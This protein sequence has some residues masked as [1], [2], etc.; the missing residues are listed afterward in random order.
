MSPNNPYL[1]GDE[2]EHNEENHQPAQEPR[3]QGQAA[4]GGG[5]PYTNQYQ[6]AAAPDL[7][8]NAPQLRSSDIKRMN[9]R[10]LAFLGG[11]VALLLVVA[12]WVLGSATSKKTEAPKQQETVTVPEAPKAF[13]Q[14]APLPKLPAPIPLANNVPPL[15]NPPMPAQFPPPQQGPRGPTLVERRMMSDSAA[16]PGDNG[17]GGYGGG[18]APNGGGYRPAYPMLPGQA[19]PNNRP[20]GVSGQQHAPLNSP[21]ALADVSNAQ[22]LNQPDTLMLR[23]TYIRCVL[24]TRIITD[25]PGFTSCIVTEPIYS[26]TGK[27]L[28]LPKGSKVLGKYDSG[29]VGNRVA[30]IWDRIVTPTGIDVNMASPGVDGLGGAGHPGTLNSHW[31]SRIGAALMISMLS[32]AFQYEAAEHG[33]RTTSVSNGI[34][35]QTPFQSNTAQTLQNLSQ[36][37]VQQAANRPA[38]VTINQGTVVDIYVAKDVDFSGVVARF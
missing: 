2:P 31:G 38:T 6:Q 22:P 19:E 17:A 9:R 7:D 14:Q 35:T 8:A 20:P 32:D 21:A 25:I 18:E 24:E 15:P 26:F 28:L 30:V 23:G 16:Q 3:Q 27:R 37:A 29:P 12:F 10:A 11:I 4:A 34:I 33:P 1:P 5:N 36:Q 13:P